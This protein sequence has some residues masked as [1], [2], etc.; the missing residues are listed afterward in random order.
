MRERVFFEVRLCRFEVW[1]TAVGVVAA[2]AVAAVAAWAV[3]IFGSEAASGRALVV[4]MAGFLV[5]ATLALALPLARVESGVLAC[6]DDVWTFLPD[7]G[8]VRAGALEVAIDLGAFLL[9]RLGDRRRA[10][11]WL[12]VQRRGLEGEWHALRCAV[13]SPPPVAGS[14]PTAPPLHL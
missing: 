11:A 3:A 9:L 13:Y 5:L 12:P 7:V 1:Q 2:V 10:S 8:P 4:G 14:S 6:R